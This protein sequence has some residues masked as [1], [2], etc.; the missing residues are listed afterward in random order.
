MLQ[1]K[2]PSW[3][4]QR[5]FET[6]QMILV[7]LESKF[8]FEE[9]ISMALSPAKGNVVLKYDPDRFREATYDKIPA[10]VSLEFNYL[11]R[12]H[13]L[14]AEQLEFS[15]DEI[16]NSTTK[17]TMIP[18]YT[19]LWKPSFYRDK[20]GREIAKALL[21]TRM[22]SIEAHNTP[23]YLKNITM[24]TV[25]DERAQNMRGYNDYREFFTLPRLKSMEELNA[26]PE[27]TKAL[28]ELYDSVD[29]I[30][31]FVGAMMEHFF[32]NCLLSALLLTHLACF[33]I[34]ILCRIPTFIL[35]NFLLAMGLTILRL[36]RWLPCWKGTSI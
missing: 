22:G 4:D 11:C 13:S 10:V 16:S 32:P 6:A 12:W 2:N 33:S 15:D 9:Y 24:R 5:T 23:G 1:V 14:V 35:E 31:L 28:K 17:T 18:F 29:D 20:G 26:G 34:K 8:V 3:D 21:R 7:H 27:A 30:D 19:T 36:R 25:L